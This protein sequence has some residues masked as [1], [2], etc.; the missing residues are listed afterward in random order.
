MNLN[1]LTLVAFATIVASSAGAVILTPDAYTPLPGSLSPGGT[2][3]EDVLESFS[4]AAYGG[5]VTGQVQN[6]VV[7]KGDGT[8]FFAWRIFNDA[9][10]S[11]KIQ[12]LRT[13]GFETP[14][15]DGD[16]D[17]TSLG[18]MAPTQ[19]FLFS[20]PGGFVNFNFNRSTDPGGL[21]PGQSS[22]FFYLDTN[23]T[24][25][26]R[27]ATYDLTNLGQTEISGQ[28]STF[29][30]V[31]EPATLAVLGIGLLAFARRKKRS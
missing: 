10:S 14:V 13:I 19:A 22:R 20:M 31:P 7:L 18:D 15:Y 23:A 8:Y 1:R 11:G 2:I 5:T 16:W 6:R 29:A 12:D 21:T 17:N 26:G 25:Y 9:N 3:V 28:Y 24:A 27:V 4:F 30:P